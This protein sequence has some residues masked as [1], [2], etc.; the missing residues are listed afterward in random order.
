M[1]RAQFNMDGRDPTGSK[2]RLLDRHQLIYYLINLF[3]YEW[4]FRFLLGTNQ[5]EL[6]KEMIEKYVP[7]DDDY[8]FISGDRVTKELQ[9]IILPTG[10]I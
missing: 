8:K 4:R 5:A 1:I 6:V 9:V 10:F 7:L 3:S 2:V